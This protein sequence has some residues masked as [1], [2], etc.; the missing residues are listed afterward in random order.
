MA[1]AATAG[2]VARERTV[3]AA[4]TVFVSAFGR[5]E[6]AAAGSA[7]AGDRFKT[8]MVPTISIG[9][10]EFM[11]LACPLAVAGRRSG[12]SPVNTDAAVA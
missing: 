9:T 11:L 2:L 3:A 1:G 10:V 4:P 7:T 8:A 12:T 6:L 5:S